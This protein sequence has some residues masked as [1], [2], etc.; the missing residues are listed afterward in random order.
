MQKHAITRQYLSN[1]DNN[2]PYASIIAAKRLDH[3]IETPPHPPDLTLTPPTTTRLSPDSAFQPTSIDTLGPDLVIWPP[4]TPSRSS[5]LSIFAKRSPT[6]HGTCPGC[7][8][9]NVMWISG[10]SGLCRFVA[11]GRPHCTPCRVARITTQDILTQVVPSI[12]P[13]QN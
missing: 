7:L 10:P 2:S 4:T 6:G 1:T 9:L 5:D 3:S 12:A 11:H 8:P 13:N